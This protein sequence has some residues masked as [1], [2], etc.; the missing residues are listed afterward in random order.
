MNFRKGLEEKTMDSFNI[1][2]M[3]P[4]ITRPGWVRYAQW[5][6][7]NDDVISSMADMFL[8]E[9]SD[10]LGTKNYDRAIVLERFLKF[11]YRNSSSAKLVNAR[12][13]RNITILNDELTSFKMTP[14]ESKSRAMMMI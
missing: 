7:D 6:E 10:T 5:L 2:T 4:K 9:V 12:R 13:L 14:F 8:V 3:Q 1:M 11:V